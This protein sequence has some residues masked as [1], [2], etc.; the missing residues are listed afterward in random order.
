MTIEYSNWLIDKIV[1]KETEGL[2][3]ENNFSETTEKDLMKTT[4]NSKV[5]TET[6]KCLSQKKLMTNR[7]RKDWRQSDFL[8]FFGFEHAFF[9]IWHKTLMF[10]N[11]LGFAGW[12]FYLKCRLLGFGIFMVWFRVWVFGFYVMAWFKGMVE[13]LVILVNG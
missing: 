11:Y 7:K 8:I 4:M 2:L 3:W 10:R 12:G 1:D 6:M 9:R 13:F 5:G